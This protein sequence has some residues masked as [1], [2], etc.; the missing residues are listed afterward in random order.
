ME[1]TAQSSVPPVGETWRYAYPPSPRSS[2]WRFAVWT[3]EVGSHAKT[4]DGRAASLIPIDKEMVPP[5]GH[6]IF[7]NKVWPV[8]PREIVELCDEDT[9]SIVRGIDG[10]MFPFRWPDAA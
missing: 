1:A 6:V 10:G 2:E 3:Y 4:V 5:V 9:Q 8:P 7:M